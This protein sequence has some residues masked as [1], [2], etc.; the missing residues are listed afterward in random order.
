M[1]DRFNRRI[2]VRVANDDR[3]CHLIACGFYLIHIKAYEQVAFLYFLT[4]ADMGFKLLSAKLY[5]VDT[6]MEKYLH[7]IA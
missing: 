7:A 1:C 2:I 5:S 4:V 3:C 6:D